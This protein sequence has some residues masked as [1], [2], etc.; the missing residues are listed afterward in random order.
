MTSVQKKIQWFSEKVITWFKKNGRKHL[1]WQQSINAYRVWISEI[2]L[3]QTQ[4]VTVISY[5]QRFL[6][7]FPTLTDLA[8][9]TEEEVL[10]YWAGLGYYARARNL[11]KAAKLLYEKGFV[12]L[13]NDIELLNSLPGI[14][15]STAGAIVSFAYGTAATILD[16]NVKRVLTRCFAIEGWPEQRVVNERLWEVAQQLTPHKY[17]QEYNQ[18]MMDLGAML[19]TR[20]KPKCSECPLQSDCEAYAQGN[21]TVFPHKKP[22]KKIP[23]RQ[24][25]FL[26]VENHGQ[27]ILLERRPP[28]GI[29]GG[30]W[31]F[32]E[33]IN[34]EVALKW[35]NENFNSSEVIATEWPIVRHQFSHFILEIL[36]LHVVVNS[37]KPVIMDG[38]N[39]E[40]FAKEKS[41]DLGIP[42]PVKRL[43]ELV[44]KLGVEA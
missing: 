30:L 35:V 42:A 25:T 28:V 32:P 19:C 36:P 10:P 43:I 6:Q 16:G 37:R 23:T 8:L 33:Y 21:P 9:A 24:S 22:A 18:A 31:S 11:L 29:W 26:I 3:Q 12:D 4:V 40:W 44:A 41:L 14:G 39:R 34:S 2:M 38:A 20:T 13:P 7:R 5:Y 15:R 1:P 17:V 27:Q